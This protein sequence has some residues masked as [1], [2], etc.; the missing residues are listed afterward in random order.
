MLVSLSKRDYSVW[1]Q[2]PIWS[3]A[4]EKQPR[5][6]VLMVFMKSLVYQLSKL[7]YPVSWKYRTTKSLARLLY[8]QHVKAYFC[9]SLY[10][11]MDPPEHRN[12][13]EDRVEFEYVTQGLTESMIEAWKN[14]EGFDPDTTVGRMFWDVFEDFVYH[15]ID[16][17]NS[18]H[19]AIVEQQ[20]Y[21]DR[22]DYSSDEGGRGRGGGG[23]RSFKRA[24]D[25]Y[26]RELEQG[27]HGDE[28]RH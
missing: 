9:P 14:V 19:G 1:L 18:R 17:D 23:R 10:I 12:W 8:A 22:S 25:I 26:Y 24:N 7:G 6:E 5:E 15:C 27:F 20:L 2:E 11:S 28:R 16:V 21:G 4:L 13:L 3:N